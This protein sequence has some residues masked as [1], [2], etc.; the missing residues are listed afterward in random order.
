MLA[1]IIAP[2]LYKVVIQPLNAGIIR[3]KAKWLL[4]C[5]SEI[6]ADE[7]QGFGTTGVV[8]LKER[9]DDCPVLKR[10][11]VPPK[12]GRICAR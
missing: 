8:N 6:I 10:V 1:S 3:W 2:W 12:L 11:S 7:N 9:E 5:M 4:E